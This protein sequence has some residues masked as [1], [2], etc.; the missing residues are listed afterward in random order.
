VKKLALRD[1]ELKAVKQQFDKLNKQAD[2][3]LRAYV[4]DIK[5]LENQSKK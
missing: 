3:K 5:L 2:A 4:T 1:S